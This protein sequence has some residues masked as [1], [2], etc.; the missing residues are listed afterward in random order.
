MGSALSVPLGRVVDA[1]NNDTPQGGV[2]VRVTYKTKNS[3]ALQWL[4]PQYVS[5]SP[6]SRSPSLD[7]R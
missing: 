2:S 5:V 4:D 1:K 6:S 7:V 3:K